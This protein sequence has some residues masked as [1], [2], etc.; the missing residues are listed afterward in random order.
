MLY[1]FEDLKYLDQEVIKELHGKV[2]KARNFTLAL[3]RYLDNK[4]K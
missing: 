3:I 1:I 2:D 4:E